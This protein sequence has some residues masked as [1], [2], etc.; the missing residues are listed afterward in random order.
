MKHIMIDLETLGLRPTSVVLSLGAVSFS[1][2]GIE[3]EYYAELGLQY[4]AYRTTDPSTIAWWATQGGIPSNGTVHPA[5]A[6]TALEDLIEGEQNTVR[7][8]ANGTDFDIPLLYSLAYEHNLA[9]AWKYSNVRDY[10]TVSRLFPGVPK[11]ANPE[12]HNALSDARTQAN[13]L[14][15]ILNRHQLWEA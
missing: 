13:H 8:W 6:V 5:V 15:R 10:R 4:Q 3:K 7:I 11:D 2:S 14:I 9:P 12:A 1:P